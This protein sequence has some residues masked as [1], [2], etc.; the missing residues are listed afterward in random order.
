[1]DWEVVGMVADAVYESLRAPLPPMLYHT[2]AQYLQLG[3]PSSASLSIRSA[4]A[5]PMTLTRGVAAAIAD[6]NPNLAL[7]FRLLP[8]VVNASIAPERIVAIVIGFFGALALLLA[9]LGLYGVTSYTVNCR[10]GEIGIRMALGAS[11]D[12]VVRLVLLRVSP[13]LPPDY[14]RRR[15]FSGHSRQ[16]GGPPCRHARNGRGQE[17]EGSQGL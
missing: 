4:A 9:A 12:G 16:R 2:F 10:R 17:W 5:S 1:M 14:P 13:A 11:P 6:V 3:P 8:D 7:T 15:H